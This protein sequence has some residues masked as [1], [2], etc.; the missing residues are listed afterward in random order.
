VEEVLRV[1]G[2]I[3]AVP[4]V[5]AEDL[6]IDGWHIPA[7]TL[8]SLGVAAANRD[9]AVYTD[10]ERLDITIE[11]EQQLTFGGG[12]HYCLG[13]NLARAELQE[14]LPIL[15]HRLGE[16]ALDGEPEWRSFAAGIFGPTRLPLRFTG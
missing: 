9:P 13:A 12:P 10:P 4:R 1:A 5:A 11:R 3:A 8:V 16:L 7:G 15:A 2:V 6:D 14:A